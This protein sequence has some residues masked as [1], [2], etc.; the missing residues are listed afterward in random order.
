MNLSLLLYSY[1]SWTLMLLDTWLSH[2]LSCFTFAELQMALSRWIPLLRRQSVCQTLY[3]SDCLLASGR[4][5]FLPDYNQPPEGSHKIL[6]VLVVFVFSCYWEVNSSGWLGLWDLLS[7]WII[8]FIKWVF[9]NCNHVTVFC[10]F[11][12]VW[13]TDQQITQCLS[14]YRLSAQFIQ[15]A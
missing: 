3:M 2:P 14:L 9:N 4:L 12:D 6:F 8:F 5:V 10:S 13:Q 7:Y 1:S 15:N 11:C